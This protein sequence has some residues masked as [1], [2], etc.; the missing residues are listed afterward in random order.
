MNVVANIDNTP[1]YTK[2]L[3]TTYTGEISNTTEKILSSKE[4]DGTNINNKNES[5]VSVIKIDT[6]KTS[7]DTFLSEDE[8][9]DYFDMLH[10]YQLSE[11]EEL[12]NYT[13]TEK[14]E[15]HA[16]PGRSQN[17]IECMVRRWI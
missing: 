8:Y 2:Y 16:L 7:K 17:Y 11:I 4:K 13:C 14:N 1:N 3:T 15:R 12:S 6:R 10:Y 9:Y 5:T